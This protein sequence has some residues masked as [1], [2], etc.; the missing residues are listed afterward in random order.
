MSE[1]VKLAY[2]KADEVLKT[3]GVIK[4]T[5]LEDREALKDLFL[6]YPDA[7]VENVVNNTYSAEK[8]ESKLG[9]AVGLLTMV[10]LL[11]LAVMLIV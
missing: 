5:A 10:S 1:Q 8:E 9:I 7:T 4:K 3:V 11:Y 6:E 2:Q